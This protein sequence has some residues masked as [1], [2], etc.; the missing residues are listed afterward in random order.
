MPDEV[1]LCSIECPVVGVELYRGVNRQFV[2]ALDGVI[3]GFGH[4]HLVG[5]ECD[6]LVLAFLAS[7]PLLFQIWKSKKQLQNT[8][9]NWI[10]LFP[11]INLNWISG[12][13]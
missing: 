3:D 6:L 1:V 4:L 7:V 12:K 9:I 2:Q 11:F 13:N 10:T 8:L 5:M